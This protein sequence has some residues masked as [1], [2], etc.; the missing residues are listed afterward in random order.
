MSLSVK[1]FPE[2]VSWGRDPHSVD[3]AMGDARKKQYCLPLCFFPASEGIHSAAAAVAAIRA[4]V[5]CLPT[6]T[7]DH[8]LLQKFPRPFNA[9]QRPCRHSRLV[10]ESPVAQHPLPHLRAITLWFSWTDT[11]FTVTGIQPP[12]P[13]HML[14]R[15]PCVF[16]AQAL[17]RSLT[18]ILTGLLSCWTSRAFSIF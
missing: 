4:N 11:S 7:G 10:N 6:W 9:P 8:P 16:Q 18:H 5:F 13:P 3:S 12:S 14:I 1:M 17:F 15:H 2:R